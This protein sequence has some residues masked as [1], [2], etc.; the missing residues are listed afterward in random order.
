MAML[1]LS[2]SNCAN[3]LGVPGLCP[4]MSSSM[5]WQCFEAL[6]GRSQRHGSAALGLW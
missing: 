6:E 3:L 2:H 5:I 4:K 1:M